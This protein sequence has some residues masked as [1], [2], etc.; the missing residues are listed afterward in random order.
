MLAV[1][2]SFAVAGRTPS[3]VGAGIDRFVTTLLPGVVMGTAIDALGDTAHLLAFG[4]AL[5]VALALFY[6]FRERERFVQ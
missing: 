6:E 1:A 2:A 3:F 4:F 5:V